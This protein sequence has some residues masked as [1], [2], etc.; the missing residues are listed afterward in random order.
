M[1]AS[2]DFTN[3]QD[4]S[5]QAMTEVALGLSMAFFALLI[6]ALISV[7]LPSEQSLE[8]SSQQSE[9]VDQRNHLDISEQLSLS[10][11]DAK[12][13]ADDSNKKNEAA[14][15]QPTILLYWQGQ[16]FDTEQ[17]V[18]SLSQMLNNN[19]FVVAVSPQIPFSQLINVQ[20]EFAG[21]QMR[22]TTL[23][24]QWQTALSVNVDKA[25]HHGL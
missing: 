14:Q 9:N 17:Q 3:M 24:Q 11:S 1:Q 23:T 25:K 21:K 19:D 18:I 15:P 8:D 22:L 4:T 20:K 13:S 6:I 10:I 2:D 5:T 12:K 16:F 7:A